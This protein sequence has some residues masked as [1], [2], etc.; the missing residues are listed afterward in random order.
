MRGANGYGRV[1]AGVNERPIMIRRR[2]GDCYGFHK[3]SGCGVKGYSSAGRDEFP[4][5][6]DLQFV[7]I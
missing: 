4:N 1:H 7:L 3:W 6:D 2:Y 5:E